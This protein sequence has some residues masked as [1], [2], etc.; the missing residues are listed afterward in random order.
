MQLDR[1]IYPDRCDILTVEFDGQQQAEAFSPA[2]W[3][4]PEVT[5]ED[6][7]ERR[8]LALNGLPALQRC[9]SRACSLR[10]SSIMLDQ[11][12]QATEATRQSAA[13]EVVVALARSLENSGMPK[14]KRN[15]CSC[16]RRHTEPLGR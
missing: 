6:T 14:V 4:G 9:R 2:P 1:V 7:Y 16:G 13:Q 11:A 10:P 5:G 8:Y 12:K 15:L 3:F